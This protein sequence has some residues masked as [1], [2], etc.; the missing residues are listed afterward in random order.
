MILLLFHIQGAAKKSAKKSSGN[1]EIK[2]KH[3]RPKK[4]EIL[5]LH[6][7]TQRLVRSESTADFIDLNVYDLRCRT[8]IL[9]YLVVQID[10]FVVA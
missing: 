6:S 8:C 3:S 7:E 1:D 2:H 10:N 4:E 5:D 9:V